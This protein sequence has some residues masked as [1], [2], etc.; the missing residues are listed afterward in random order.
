MS[1]KYDLPYMPYVEARFQFGKQKPT[2][3]LLRGSFTT[4]NKGAAL[5]VAQMWHSA[6]DPWKAGHYTIDEELRFRCVEDH[7]V[8]G[9]QE[10]AD[11]GGIRIA[12]CAEPVGRE[13]FWNEKL[14]G[15]V[16]NKAARLVA[17]LTLAHKI[18]VRYLDEQALAKWHKH[19]WRKRGGIFIEDPTTGFPYESFLSEVQ[20]QRALKKH[21]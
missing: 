19:P 6:P 8:A 14:H 20:A 2:A 21:I 16:L 3:I 12:V 13:I 18:P 5:G 4:S 7:V 1:S 10:C 9:T 15:L 11:R 17:E